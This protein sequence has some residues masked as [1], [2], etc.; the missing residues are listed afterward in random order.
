MNCG[1]HSPCGAYFVRLSMPDNSVA[2]SPSPSPPSVSGEVAAA[3]SDVAARNSSPFF[4]VTALH[5]ASGRTYGVKL[6]PKAVEKLTMDAGCVKE[7]DVFA[8]MVHGALISSTRSVSFSVV[9]FDEIERELEAQGGAVGN[10]KVGGDAA[11]GT[12]ARD[13]NHEVIPDSD[14][15]ALSQLRYFRLDYD[16]MF[17]KTLF[18]LPLTPTG[19]DA[20][21]PLDAA[22]SA[23]PPA[24]SDSMRRSAARASPSPRTLPAR[25]ATATSG[26]V[27]MDE[28]YRENKKLRAANE[29]LER[30]SVSKLKEMEADCRRIE[31]SAVSDCRKEIARLRQQL[32]DARAENSQLRKE[33]QHLQREQQQQQ[34]QQSRSRSSRSQGRFDTPPRAT[35]SPYR[36][37]SGDGVCPSRS[38]YRSPGGRPLTPA[39]R[40]NRFDSPCKRD[41]REYRSSRASDD[42]RSSN[43]SRN[44][45]RPSIPR[46]P[47]RSTGGYA[48]PNTATHHGQQPLRSQPERRPFH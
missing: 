15:E 7:F 31:N 29:A 43:H 21:S 18:I 3:P 42:E 40:S 36:A 34:Q 20:S 1:V 5:K 2:P 9:T 32:Q 39:R 13:K 6:G 4:Q 16:V 26:D 25:T 24:E 11:G 23:S 22:A 44:S 10:K 46:S 33:V 48:Y 14:R 47:Y 28:L 37:R 45:A 27:S 19:C 35:P 8:K 12:S 38:P 30:L 17:T 41:G